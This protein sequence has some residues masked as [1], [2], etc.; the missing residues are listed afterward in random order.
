MPD[1][2]SPRVQT[3]FRVVKDPDNPY[4]MMDK[5]PIN[6]AKLSFKAKGILAYVLSKPNDWETQIAD[7]INHGTEGEYAIR[8]GI[9][10]LIDAG[11]CVRRNERNADGSFNRFVLEFYEQPFRGF[12]QVGNP[13]VG[14]RALNNTEL[15]NT[16]LTNTDA[17]AA[18][19]PEE[20]KPNPLAASTPGGV[21]LLE[22][23][24]K[25]AAARRGGPVRG[26]TKFPTLAIKEKFEKAEARIGAQM[27]QAIQRALEVG[28]TSVPR[29]VDYI[30]KWGTNGKAKPLS[31]PVPDYDYEAL[32][33]IAI[34]EGL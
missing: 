1:Q 26:F 6:D 11:Y 9:K 30:A 31:Q 32:R 34:A 12:P 8:A 13:H 18:P 5:R 24:K 4:V 14:N 20:P 10:E 16:E 15:T 23:L 7:L 3:I 33:Q 22:A 17:P 25:E 27:D 19:A 28:C 2:T 21:K 29:A